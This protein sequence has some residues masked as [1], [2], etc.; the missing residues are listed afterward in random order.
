LDGCVENRGGGY[1]DDDG[2]NTGGDETAHGHSPACRSFKLIQRNSYA[3]G[4]AKQPV[5]RKLGYIALQHSG[6]GAILLNGLSIAPVKLSG[7]RPG[8][9]FLGV[10]DASGPITSIKF[11]EGPSGEMDVIGSYATA[12][13]VS[14]PEIEPT[15][16]ASGLALL[17]GALAVLQ[18]G[19][20]NLSLKRNQR[21]S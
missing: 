15:T 3:Y 17:L 4:S 5:F 7:G 1:R 21:P 14:A 13:A 18:G 11:S 10:T 9:A 2:N 19:G 12:S 16:A 6:A 20:S 8:S